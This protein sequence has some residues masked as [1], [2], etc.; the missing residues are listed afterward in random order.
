MYFTYY[1]INAILYSSKGTTKFQ[2]K[3]T[4]LLKEDKVMLKKLVAFLK[5]YYE[6]CG[7]GRA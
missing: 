1:H 3:I 7:R 4:K 2:T 5:E 6:E